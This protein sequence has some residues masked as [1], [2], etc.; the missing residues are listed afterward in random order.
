MDYISQTTERSVVNNVHNKNVGTNKSVLKPKREF[1]E[2]RVVENNKMRTE[3][4][5]SKNKTS[6]F[7]QPLKKSLTETNKVLTTN[8]QFNDAEIQ[9]DSKCTCEDLEV[10]ASKVED[11]SCY[12]KLHN[13]IESKHDVVLSEK[14]E[15]EE[16]DSGL[17]SQI[18]EV[19]KKN[20]ELKQAINDGRE[21]AEAMFEQDEQWASN[22]FAQVDE[23][24]EN[25]NSDAS[26]EED[27]CDDGLS[28]DEISA[29]VK[30]MLENDQQLEAIEEIHKAIEAIEENEEIPEE[31]DTFEVFD[32]N[33]NS[34]EEVLPSNTGVYVQASTCCSCDWSTAEHIKYMTTSHDELYYMCQYKT[35]KNEIEEYTKIIP[36][37]KLSVA[38]K[39]E[40]L[41][42][43][44]DEQVELI[45]KERAADK[46]F[47]LVNNAEDH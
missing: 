17:E 46:L 19:E 31:S 42:K 28:V 3:D 47:E 29:G 15:L 44:Q 6:I 7:G 22:I 38:E 21:L 25:E 13:E 26:G 37:L 8:P 40:Q 12:K 24:I 45:I 14:F 10:Y 33:S 41:S 32:E 27:D 23:L 18:A 9:T 34:F 36:Q 30:E 43:L 2:F 16:Q 39:E 20:E 11:K 4:T 35:K 1:R 5:L